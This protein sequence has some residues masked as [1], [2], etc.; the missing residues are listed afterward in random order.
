MALQGDEGLLRTLAK[1]CKDTREKIRYLALHALSKGY[2]VSLVAEVFCVDEATIY[3]W[4]ERWRVERSLA[5]S[6][7]KEDPQ[8]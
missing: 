3:R 5:D 7:K 4:I 2:T 6:P 1:K 8:N